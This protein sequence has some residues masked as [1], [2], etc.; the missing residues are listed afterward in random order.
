MKRK[1]ANK[2]VY[3][4]GNLGYSVIGQTITNFFMFYGTSVLKVPGTLVGVAIAISTFWD[5]FT[6]PIVGFISDHYP[7]K[8]FGNRTGYMFFATFGMALV[9]LFIW[10]VPLNIS[11]GIKF[12]WILV[13]LIAIETFNT[14]YSTPYMALSSDIGYG[15]HERTVVQISKT[16]FLL[17]GM[18]ISSLL[19]YVFLPNT[20]AFPVGQLNPMGYRNMAI[21][22]SAI[23]I[24]CGLI[25]VFGTRK[26]VKIH[27]SALPTEKFSFKQMW[28]DFASS[29]QNTQQRCIILGYSISLLSGVILT[30]VGMH[31]FTYCF[32]FASKQ[33][34]ILLASLIL[35]TISSQP[36]WFY[37]SKKHDKK[38][39]LLSSMFVSVVGVFCIITLFLLRKSL[40]KVAFF[41]IL[42]SVFVCGFGSGAL[43]SLPTSIYNDIIIKQNKKLGQNKTATYSGMLTFSCNIANSLALLVIGGLLDVIKFDPNKT[44]Q[45]LSVQTGLALILFVGVQIALIL[46]YYIFSKYNPR[47]IAKKYKNKKDILQ[48]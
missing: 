48:N 17:L 44:T 37:I 32:N 33:I 41:L 7:I 39:A 46:G 35:G 28:K 45:T 38:P 2:F 24:L 5:G 1:K 21:I 4:I 6:D 16:I 15:Y 8:G 22:T 10:F 43:Y 19:L 47:N 13:G 9:N 14:L 40:G 34:T 36:L 29:L 12:L 23:C 26:C 42:I 30:S 18:I 20:E 25:C 3:G 11:T 31:F 27:N